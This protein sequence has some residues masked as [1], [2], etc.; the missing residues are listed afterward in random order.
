M[1]LISMKIMWYL[2][3]YVPICTDFIHLSNDQS[4]AI[5]CNAKSCYLP[6]I[7]YNFV[8]FKFKLH[9]YIS[10]PHLNIPKQQGMSVL[11]FFPNATVFLYIS[12]TA[13]ST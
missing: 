12:A 1:N 3:A 9:L 6:F 11:T 4:S 8:V 2:N 10:L 5:S 7:T 13:Y